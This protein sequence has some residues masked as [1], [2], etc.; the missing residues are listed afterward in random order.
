MTNQ[1]E[2]NRAN[3]QHST[4]PITPEGKET[5][6]RNAT[7]HGLTSRRLFLRPE[8]KS[9]FQNLQESLVQAWRP[10][11]AQESALVIQI[12]EA[13]WRLDAAQAALDQ[14]VFSASTGFQALSPG[15]PE[16]AANALAMQAHTSQLLLYQR[17][18][19]GFERTLLRL[20]AALR[21]LQTF[22]M[23]KQKQESDTERAE[24]KERDQWDDIVDRRIQNG[25]TFTFSELRRLTP[26]Q[27]NRYDAAQAELN[28]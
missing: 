11:D 19:T 10:A 28:Q 5:S 3:A 4:G 12:A 8:Q 14:L 15:M 25:C 26:D 24:S 27:R 13:Q 18:A 7:R 17:Y 1:Q 21:Q 20:I 2:A 22:R 16:D 9:E 23:K 6:S